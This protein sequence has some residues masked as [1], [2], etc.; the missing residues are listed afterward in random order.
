MASAL[1]YLLG[2]L[3]GVLFL[4]L[5]PYNRNKTIRFH[6]FQSIFMNVACFV[7][8]IASII[9]IGVLHFIPV[10]GTVLS[11]LMYPLLGLG[12][13][14]LWIF[15]MYKAYNRERFVLPIIGPLAE[16]QA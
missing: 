8:W 14:G 11:L 16:K 6:A 1:C 2:W 15:L 7:V 4:V 5:E 12:F 3:T 10:I 13:F 9:I